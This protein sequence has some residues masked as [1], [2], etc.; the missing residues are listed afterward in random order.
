MAL[1]FPTG[2]LTV[3]QTFTYAST[4]YTWDGT[5]WTAGIS[6]T[7]VTTFSAGTTGLTPATASSSA[8]TLAG[9]L[10]VANGGTGRTTTNPKLIGSFAIVAG[11]TRCHST[12]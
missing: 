7:V 9:T 6:S 3:G 2:T 10:A 5:K 8:V 11:A 12:G 4:T 1:T